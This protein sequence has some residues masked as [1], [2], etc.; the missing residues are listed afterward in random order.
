MKIPSVI[1]VALTDDHDIFRF[2][3][4]AM[5]KEQPQLNLVAEAENFKELMQVAQ[6][7]KPDVIIT[8]IKAPKTDSLKTIQRIME[9]SPNVAVIVLN[10][11]NDANLISE[12]LEAG[13]K[14]HLSKKAS[15]REI[16]KA[17]E[18]VFKDE[19]YCCSRTSTTLAKMCIRHYFPANCENKKVG[20]IERERQIITLI[21]EQ[22]TNQ[23]IAGKLFLGKRTIE[24]YRDHI[25]RK[26]GVK[27]TAGIVLY[28]IR[29]GLFTI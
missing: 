23:E 6:Q 21:C 12:I 20:F 7:H 24:T 17:I 25:M 11:S 9:E 1:R 13:V 4:G 3:L 15:R 2:G 26:M 29:W 10:D 27:N 14:G 28:A 16:V 22:Y 19:T 8:D 18:A 5:I